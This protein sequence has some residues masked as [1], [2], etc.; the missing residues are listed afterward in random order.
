MP[1][2]LGIGLMSGTSA[3]A[4]DAALVEIDASNAARPVRLVRFIAHPMPPSLQKRLFRVM[5]PGAPTSASEVCQLNV[6]VGRL[7]A[8]AA[9]S[10]AGSSLPDVEWVGSHG[11][12]IAHVPRVDEARGWLTRS[13]LQIGEPSEMAQALG[14]TVV[15]DFRPRDMACGGGGA[16]L[17][18]AAEAVLFRHLLRGGGGGGGGGGRG[19][20]GGG[21]EGERVSDQGA[22]LVLQN[23]GGMGSLTALSAT[24]DVIASF[25]TGPGNMVMDFIVRER[26]ASVDKDNAAAPHQ[27]FDAG[28]ALAAQGR[29]VPSA[30]TWALAH[31]FFGTSPPRSGG[32]EHFGSEFARAFYERCDASS[33]RGRLP[34]DV[35]CDALRTALELTAVTI[36]DSIRS[37]VGPIGGSFSLPQGDGGDDGVDW[38]RVATSASARGPGRDDRGCVLLSGGGANNSTLVAR[39]RELAPELRW[40]TTSEAGVDPDAKEAVGFAVLGYLTLAGCVGNSHATGAKELSVLGK[41]CHPGLGK[42]IPT[43]EALE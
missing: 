22:A 5:A 39:L 4:V 7:F 42:A 19:G 33:D 28:G 9:I 41:I 35:T 20:G 3:D 21:D 12:T 18:P 37:H 40:L 15:A 30:L 11:Q 38:A 13:S 6:E 8:D 31:R 16:P 23:I 34:S 2:H 27:Q 17:M 36:V 14:V 26:G 24:G 25:D 10:V 1:A 29:V 32:H 43:F